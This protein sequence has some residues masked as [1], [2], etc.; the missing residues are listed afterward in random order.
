MGC[1]EFD[2]GVSTPV[3]DSEVLDLIDADFAPVPSRADVDAAWLAEPR[4][5]RQD[6]IYLLWKRRTI[7]YVETVDLVDRWDVWAR[8]GEI[9]W[10]IFLKSLLEAIRDD[11]PPPSTPD[12][13]H[14]GLRSN[15]VETP[16]AGVVR[17]GIA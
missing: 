1:V 2:G 10:A 12:R 6:A 14:P 3:C 16:L 11:D 5:K 4:E 13:W 7:S 8:E 15:A 9:D 17:V